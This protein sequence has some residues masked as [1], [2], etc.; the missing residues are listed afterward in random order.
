MDKEKEDFCIAMGKRVKEARRAAG[1]KGEE[2]A[3]QAGI[4][5]QFLSEVERGRKG[6][7]SY[8]LAPL[9]RTLRVTSDFL[10]FGRRDMDGRV[11]M[12]AEH[13]ASIPPAQREM[14]ID[15]LEFALD[16]IRYNIPE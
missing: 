14:A 13:L 4:T 6:I 3:E 1:L 5:A 15:T 16:M 11:Q 12:T 2:A 8:Y 10:L 9:A 7:T